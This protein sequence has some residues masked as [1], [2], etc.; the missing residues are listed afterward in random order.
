[1]RK[2]VQQQLL[3]LQWHPNQGM[4]LEGSTTAARLKA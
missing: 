1:M 2:P 3:Q 4:V